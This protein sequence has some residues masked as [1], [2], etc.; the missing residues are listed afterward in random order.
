M[1]NISIRPRLRDWFPRLLSGQAHQIIGGPDDPYLLRWYVIPRNPVLNVYLHKFCRS[2]DDRA[3]H[4]H[5]W[6]FLSLILRGRYDEITE[7]GTRRRNAGSVAYRPAE[8]RHRVRLLDGRTYVDG[9]ILVN[10]L[11]CWT[12]IVTGRRLRTWGFWCREKSCPSCGSAIPGL[13][14][15]PSVGYG[16]YHAWH[17]VTADAADRELAASLRDEFGDCAGPGEH[18][19]PWDEFG[20]A[21]CGEP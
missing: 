11:P 21:G 13:R 14:G 15:G 20:D 6:W 10:P 8:W 1:S 7:Q 17:D 5:P 19:I 16:C 3:L 18:F 4:D 9:R 12:L 2:D